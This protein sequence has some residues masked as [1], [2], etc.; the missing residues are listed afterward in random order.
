MKFK[1]SL[2]SFHDTEDNAHIGRRP[3]HLQNE[4]N[5]AYNKYHRQ[6]VIYASLTPVFLVVSHLHSHA[7]NICNALPSS[8]KQSYSLDI[9]N[10]KLTMLHT[11]FLCL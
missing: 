7:N 1:G 3:Q 8:V 5:T 9:C 6:E 4:R 10:S 11:S 2:H